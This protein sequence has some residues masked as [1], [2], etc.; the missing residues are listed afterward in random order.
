MDNLRLDPVLLIVFLSVMLE[1]L[2]LLKK[3]KYVTLERIGLNGRSELILSGVVF[4]NIG[5]LKDFFNKWICWL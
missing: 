5:Y 1:Y 3:Q 4:E 2:V